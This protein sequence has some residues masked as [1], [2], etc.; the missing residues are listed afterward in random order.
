MNIG[1]HIACLIS[2]LVFFRYIPW[3]GFAVSDC[4]YILNFLRN[5]HT[6]FHCGCISLYF[7]QRCMRILFSL[8]PCQH[9]LYVDFNNSNWTDI[10]WY[11]IVVWI[12]ISLM[13]SDVEHLFICSWAISMS[14]LE[15]KFI[16]IVFSFY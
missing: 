9:L 14:S 3:C 13:T 10:S 16:Q 1:V 6:I 15:E 8:H 5:L 2:V 11:L 7:H 12:C 4:S